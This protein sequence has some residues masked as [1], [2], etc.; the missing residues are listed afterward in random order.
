M[1]TLQSSC[2][3]AAIISCLLCA[4]VV[5]GNRAPRQFK[6]LVVYLVLESLRFV[7]QWLMLQPAAP[8]K[9]LWMGLLFVSSFLV[10]PALWMFARE[11]AEGRTPSLRQ[12]RGPHAA[13]MLAGAMLTMPLLLR[14]HLG[15][16]YENPNDVATPMHSLFIHSTMLAAIL[17]FLCQVPYYLTACLRLLGNHVALSKAMFS[18]LEPGSMKT[19]RLLI[20]IVCT[21]WLVGLLRA[22]YSLTFGADNVAGIVFCVLEVGVTAA[23]VFTLMR[24]TTTFSIEERA[25]AQE[26]TGTAKYARSA[27]DPPARSRIQRKLVQAMTSRL[28]RDSGVT[29]RSLC[30]SLKENPHYVSQVINQDLATSFYEWIKKH[31]IEDAMNAL[32]AEPEKSVLDIA[33]EVGFNSKSTFNAAFRQHAGMTPREF[34]ASRIRTCV[35]AAPAKVAG[36]ACESR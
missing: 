34:R 29:L 7:F 4:F 3:A 33:L 36:A 25:F 11:I 35:E 2:Y 5:G 24:R 22:S 14:T 6:Y 19:L 17:L 13:V 12:L 8:A 27:L 26:L 10:A 21:N 16:T 28:H 23:V 20:F 32:V 15:T 1:T 18:D 31:R 30:E 9:A